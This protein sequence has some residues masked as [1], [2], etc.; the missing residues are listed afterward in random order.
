MA[1]RETVERTL[2]PFHIFAGVALIYFYIC[3]ALASSGRYLE[4]R[5]QYVH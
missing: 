2:A 1:G 5:M 3:F 4:Q